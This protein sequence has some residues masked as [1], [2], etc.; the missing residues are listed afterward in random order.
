MNVAEVL[1]AWFCLKLHIDSALDASDINKKD[2]DFFAE[3]ENDNNDEFN[4]SNNNYELSAV[5]KVSW[6]KMV[7]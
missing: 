5:S 6:C 4:L 7:Y 3:C 2:E 1:I